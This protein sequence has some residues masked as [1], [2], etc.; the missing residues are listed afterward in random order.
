MTSVIERALETVPCDLVLVP[1]RSGATARLV[2]RLKPPRWL[3]A[4]SP[5]RA[6]CQ[7]LAFSYG[8]HAVENANEDSDW[9]DFIERWLRANHVTAQRV[10][11]IAGPSPRNPR[12]SHRIELIRLKYLTSNNAMSHKPVMLLI[13]DGWGINPGGREAAAE[14]NGDATLLART[15]FH[16]ELYRKYPRARLSASGSRCRPAR[17]TNGEFRGRP[18]EPGRGP[19]RLSG[20]DPDQ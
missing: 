6:V 10:L 18:H 8:V 16:D 3:I 1:T 13:R 5:D 9:R 7:G 14:A 20:P 17:R 15:P 19:H 12:A 4:P 11:L 2:A